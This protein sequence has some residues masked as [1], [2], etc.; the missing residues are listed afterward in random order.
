ML[1]NVIPLTP[2]ARTTRPRLT[3]ATLKA[4]KPEGTPYDLRSDRAPGLLLRVECSGTMTYW[5]QLER[6]KR[7]KL[8]D[9]KILTLAQA[10]DRARR[11]LADP[12]KYLQERQKTTTLEQFV[13]DHY[14]PFVLAHRKT[15]AATLARLK[16]NF[17]KLY[18][19]RLNELTFALLER[20]RTDRLNSGTAK[21]TVNRDLVSLSA[22][23]TKAVQLK[24]LAV[25]PLRELKPLKVA[26]GKVRFLN[27]KEEARLRAALTARDAVLRTK[28]ENG[29]AWRAAR[30]HAALPDH[31]T[32]GDHLTP[33]VLLSMN[34][35]MRQGEVF[36]LRWDDVD[37]PRK[38]VSVRAEVAKSGK[39][40]Y[41]NLNTEATHVLT[42]WQRQT[43]VD[44]G[45]V[46][47]GKEGK[48]FV[49]VKKAWA[50]LLEDAKIEDFR[51]H[52]LRHHFA[53][54]FV[55]A[56]GDLNTLREL[57]GHADIKMVL[58]YAHLSS[59]HKAAAVERISGMPT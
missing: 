41:I 29:N 6:T 19:K 1:N 31:G 44:V 30:G 12:A 58:R 42:H 59:E 23:L 54:R 10:E 40:R 46:F 14:R 49:D 38:L 3:A 45:L 22:V 34:T 21:A 4:A 56:G 52:D 48:V 35:G 24:A 36:T 13:E 43:G 9:A 2:T 55:M 17:G 18:G 26:N 16:S 32:Y 57:L 39:L 33:M 51:W 28:R 15:G 5:V 27:P 37:L 20:W 25:N 7:H 47:P 53:S 8:G 50:T 11:V